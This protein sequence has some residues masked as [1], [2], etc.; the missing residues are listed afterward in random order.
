MGTVRKNRISKYLFT[1]EKEL[2]KK[3]RGSHEEY[4][5]QIKCK[6]LCFLTWKDNCIVN[7]LYIFAGSQPES[8]IQRFDHRKR[9]ML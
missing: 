9:V 7:L 1:N 6:P 4:V 2:M 8:K 3:I 5:S